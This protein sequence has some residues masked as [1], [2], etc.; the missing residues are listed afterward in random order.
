MSTTHQW[1]WRGA[2]L[3][4][5][6]TAVGGFALGNPLLF[7]AG[8]VPLAYV[9]YDYL[10]VPLNPDLVFE[11]TVDAETAVP[12]DEVSV[13]LEITTESEGAA[14]DVRVVDGVPG[15]LPVVDGSPR[16]AVAVPPNGSVTLEYTVR[17]RRGV[18]EFDD[19]CYQ[20]R[21]VQ[22]GHVVTESASPTGASRFR[23]LQ[24]LS[25]F[26]LPNR[27]RQYVGRSESDEG[28]EGVEFYGSRE[29]Q[30]GDPAN[31]ID[32]N[33]LAGTGELT[34]LVHREER[35]RS[36]MFV[37]DTR[38][39]AAVGSGEGTFTAV[40]LGTYAVERGVRALQ[41]DNH[42]VGLTVIGDD[43]AEQS[44]VPPGGG[45][46]TRE[47]IRYVLS[48]VGPFVADA[49]D[50]PDEENDADDS[51]E[52][53][54]P[55]GE[56]DDDEADTDDESDMG[57]E[58][59]SEGNDADDTQSPEAAGGDGR[60]ADPAEVTDG[61]EDPIERLV[62][63]VDARTQVVLVSPVLDAEPVRL[64]ER[65][66]KHGY[67]STVLSPDVTGEA[68]WGSRTAALDRRARLLELQSQDAPVVDWDPEE[69]L[70][71]ALVRGAAEPDR[72]GADATGVTEDA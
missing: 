46:A 65:L 2:V 36:V 15:P 29:Y 18:H 8:A 9:A 5:F 32:W 3:L 39:A 59:G 13:R 68:T 57:D 50:A 63:D 21:S 72:T 48:R 52:S 62:A 54:A 55:D 38:P 58:P 27:T 51:A 25:S 26:P 45:T 31:R 30:P 37:L 71:M 44:F 66:E 33:R 12:G 19:V 20:L 67:A 14:A 17:A 24:H 7:V 70:G 28:G 10:S 34:T 6:A 61:G 69:S 43:S 41:E 23:C 64:V 35:S 16:A 56:S 47:R 22:G 49:L 11:R 1:R 60:E 53:D 42:S 4:T 40:E